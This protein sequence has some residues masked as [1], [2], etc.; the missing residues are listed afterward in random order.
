M[1]LK[2][3]EKILSEYHF[4][5][6]KNL[7]NKCILT[8]SRLVFLTN[9]SE[10]NYPLSKVTSVKIEKQKGDFHAKVLGFSI[11]FMLIL[12]AITGVMI[13]GYNGPDWNHVL[14]LIPFYLILIWLI[15][16][17]FKPEKITANLV[18]TQFGGTKKYSPRLTKEL[19]E[20]IDKVNETLI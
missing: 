17:G 1:K 11:V 7:L 19:Q 12:L 10:E 16:F 6:D 14:Y 18:I 3:G 2:E 8:D 15:K 9:N 20:F 5:K 13:F 4:S